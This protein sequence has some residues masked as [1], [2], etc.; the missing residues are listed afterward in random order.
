MNVTTL[1]ELANKSSYCDTYK[2]SLLRKI[3]MKR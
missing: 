1:V 2:C 3:F